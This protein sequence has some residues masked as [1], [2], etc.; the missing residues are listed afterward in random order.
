MEVQA[1]LD[2]FAQAYQNITCYTVAGILKMLEGVDCEHLSKLRKLDVSSDA[3]VLYEIPS[4][5]K[6][7]AGKLVRR[8]WTEYGL[9]Y[10]MQRFEENNQ[11]SFVLMP[12]NV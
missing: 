8:W 7:I 6:K 5:I 2:T 4:D 11:V 12:F 1:L 9:P 10:C 3:S